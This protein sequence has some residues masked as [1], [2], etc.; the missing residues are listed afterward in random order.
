MLG[1]LPQKYE[2]VYTHKNVYMIVHTLFVYNSPPDRT[3]KMS[4]NR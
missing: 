2:N 1:H 4:S 3:T